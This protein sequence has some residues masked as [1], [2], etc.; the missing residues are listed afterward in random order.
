[1]LKVLIT[2]LGLILASQQT[3]AGTIAATKIIEPKKI[4]LATNNSHPDTLK[5]VLPS[6]IEIVNQESENSELFLAVED[7]HSFLENAIL[8]ARLA[9]KSTGLP[10]IAEASGIT[11][12]NNAVLKNEF[13]VSYTT[14]LAND[15]KLNN[16]MLDDMKYSTDGRCDAQYNVVLV[17][18]SNPE[19][20]KPIFIHKTVKG[21]IVRQPIDDKE[22]SYDNVFRALASNRI[23]GEVE[24][25]FKEF[26]AKLANE[27]NK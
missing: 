18:M 17:Y 8:K 20:P 1:M 16:T 4:V 24:H 7:K 10:A 6:N 19:D 23:D 22:Y 25:I 13:N 3:F 14:S 2:S 12:I 11:V 21:E 26:S 15:K 9:S 5:K 27:I